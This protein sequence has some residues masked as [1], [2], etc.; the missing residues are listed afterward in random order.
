MR[1]FVRNLHILV[2]AFLSVSSA[3]WVAGSPERAVVIM[4]PLV[5]DAVELQS[6]GRNLYRDVRQVSW[7][8]LKNDAMEVYVVGLRMPSMLFERLAEKLREAEAEME[9]SRHTD[10]GDMQN[11]LR[12]QAPKTASTSELASL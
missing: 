1:F 2:F 10:A 11:E 4:R 9:R 8:Q 5:E 6:L 7:Q 12:Q 3:F